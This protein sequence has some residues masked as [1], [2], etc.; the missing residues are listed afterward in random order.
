M[1]LNCII[2]D[3]SESCISLLSGYLS[4][5]K[6]PLRLIRT[7]TNP[8][9]ALEEMQYTR[10]TDIAF[11]GTLKGEINGIH[12]A[13]LL[14]DKIRYLIITAFDISHALEAFDVHAFNYLL[15]PILKEKFNETLKKVIDM[16]QKKSAE[17]KPGKHFFIKSNIGEQ[18]KIYVND[19]LA[20]QGASNYVKIHTSGKKN[21]VTYGKMLDY[22]QRLSALGS[23][24]RISKSFI[25]ST[26]AI[27][28]VEKRKITLNNGLKVMIGSTY[29]DI[30]KGYLNMVNHTMI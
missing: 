9:T 29:K 15:K 30:L 26:T 16:E 17:Q 4:A 27:V 21:Y 19:I 7:Y 24:I 13:R 20:I 10:E 18:T 2:I 22:E 1:T 11:I 14:R 28:L 12:L 25:I 8:L 3:D 6:I 23:F 5:S